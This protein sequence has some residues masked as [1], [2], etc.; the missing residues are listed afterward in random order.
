MFVA[1]DS[2]GDPVSPRWPTGGQFAG[3][4]PRKLAQQGRCGNVAR[5]TAENLRLWQGNTP[6]PL[7]RPCIFSELLQR[8]ELTL[9]QGWELHC[10]AGRADDR[11]QLPALPKT[12]LEQSLMVR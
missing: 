6:Q 10:V 9:C 1:V 4:P 5:Y 12:K 3:V 8:H 7:E 11:P 2:L